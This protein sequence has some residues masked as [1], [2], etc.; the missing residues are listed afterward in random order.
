MPFRFPLQAVFHFRQS[1]EH[2]QEMLLRAANQR[3]AKV[4][5]LLDQLDALIC[6]EGIIFSERLAA[7]TTSAELHFALGRAAAL[8]EHHQVLERELGRVQ[9]LR[10]QRQA[11]FHQA[12]QQREILESLR[13]QQLR[14]Y[15]QAASRREQRQI[16]ELFL[17]RQNYLRR[18]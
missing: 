7:G 14:E 2:Q 18:G 4:R 17:L 10:D 3:V 9:E 5:H 12:R 1:I 13:D 16:D 15:N 11:V 8:R 6:K